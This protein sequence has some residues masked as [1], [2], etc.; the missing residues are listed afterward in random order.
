M[1]EVFRLLKL[2]VWIPTSRESNFIP[3]IHFHRAGT[4]I[5]FPNQDPT[6]A[7]AWNH[8]LSSRGWNPWLHISGSD[9]DSHPNWFKTQSWTH[10]DEVFRLIKLAVWRLHTGT[11]KPACSRQVNRPCAKLEL[12]IKPIKQKNHWFLSGYIRCNPLLVS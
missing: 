9:G 5:H 7:L 1:D 2:A 6:P 12:N 3:K 10:M 8:I 11:H 4:K